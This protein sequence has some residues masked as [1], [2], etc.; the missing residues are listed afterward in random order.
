[1]TFDI[2]H[3]NPVGI[4]NEI[5]K[6]YSSGK[7]FARAIGEDGSDVIRWRY[8][9]SA[10]KARAVVAICRLYPQIPPYKLN[11][12]IFPKELNFVFSEGGYGNDLP[13]K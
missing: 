10:I 11:P 4:I 7:A 5:L 12:E 9:R 3:L 1:M 13:Q 6:E 2:T 8:G